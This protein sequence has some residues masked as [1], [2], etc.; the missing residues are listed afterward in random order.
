MHVVVAHGD[1][2]VH[3]DVVRQGGHC[4]EGLVFDVLRYE[5]GDDVVTDRFEVFLKIV[6]TYHPAPLNGMG[7]QPVCDQVYS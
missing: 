2:L 6:E 5:Y 1:A 7:R 3:E 4:L